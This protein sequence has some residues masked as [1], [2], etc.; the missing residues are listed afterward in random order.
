MTIP[1]NT[2]ADLA[3]CQAELARLKEQLAQERAE[4]QRLAAVLTA[5][6]E[7]FSLIYNNSPV[8]ITLT[9]LDGHFC[10][11]NP[12]FCLL[13]G[14]PEA[15]LLTM[16]V[17]ALTQPDDMA[18]E[19][20]LTQQILA[21]TSLTYQIERQLIKQNGETIW[22]KVNV[23]GHRQ[24]QGEVDYFVGMAED[25]TARRQAEANLRRQHDFLNAILDLTTEGINVTDADD[26]F[27]FITG[28]WQ[29]SPAT[30]AKRRKPLTIW[31]PFT[32][33]PPTW[34]GP[35]PL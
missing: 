35:G 18:Q 34:I 15:D 17:A 9:T 32:P 11:V 2:P 29:K 25:I 5:S 27:V 33:S 24:E 16:N 13:T 1:S 10:A 26:N 8:G 23:S 21:G 14:Y 3:A 22:V 19:L 7:R 12:A 28:R 20:A 30:A 31:P 4:G 6:E